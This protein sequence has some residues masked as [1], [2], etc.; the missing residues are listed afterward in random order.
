MG[1]EPDLPALFKKDHK[2]NKKTKFSTESNE[3][4]ENLNRTE[5][6]TS[7]KGL[8]SPQYLTIYAKV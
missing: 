3:K 5:I 2:L 7:M 6:I 8:C 1:G 4:H